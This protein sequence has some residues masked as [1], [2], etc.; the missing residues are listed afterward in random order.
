MRY[1]KHIYAIPF[2]FFLHFAPAKYIYEMDDLPK[3]FLVLLCLV[4]QTGW[5][6]HEI[7]EPGA[8]TGC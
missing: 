4:L 3:S 7:E 5:G 1:G 2:F 6:I 8:Y